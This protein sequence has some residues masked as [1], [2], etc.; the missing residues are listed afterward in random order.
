MKMFNGIMVENVLEDHLTK[1][2]IALQKMSINYNNTSPFQ[3]WISS[4][5]QKECG[6]TKEKVLYTTK[7]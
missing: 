3:I 2:E 4:Q 5:T 7:E 6:D 1:F